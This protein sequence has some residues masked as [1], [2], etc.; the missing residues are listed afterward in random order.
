MV[1]DKNRVF[2]FPDDAE[3]HYQD[4]LALTDRFRSVPVHSYAGYNGP[5]I[6]WIFKSDSQLSSHHSENIFIANYSQLPLSFFR[7]FIPIF[8]QWIDTEIIN[9][10][11]YRELYILLKKTLRPNVIYLAISQV[12]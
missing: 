9:K 2:A 10:A 6:G 7:G 11:M 5:W 3:E 1:E 8:V 4:L 12:T